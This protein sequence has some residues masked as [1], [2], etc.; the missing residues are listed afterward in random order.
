MSVFANSRSILHKGDGNTHVAAPPDVCKTPSPGGPIP[1][2]YVNTAS[3]SNLSKGA[4][5][6]KIEGNAA[7]K[8]DSE[9]SVSM[10][11]DAG[12]AGGVVSN[13]FK[14]KLTWSSASTDVKIEGKGAVRFTDPTG[15]NANTF[16]TAFISK[17][18]TGQAY[19]DDLPCPLCGKTHPRLESTGV[20][21]ATLHLF[22]AVDNLMDDKKTPNPFRAEEQHYCDVA[23]V[24]KEIREIQTFMGKIPSLLASA[25][26][27]ARIP[28]ATPADYAATTAELKRI[29]QSVSRAASEGRMKKRAKLTDQFPEDSQV[30][31]RQLLRAAIRVMDANRDK[32]PNTAA[33]EAATKASEDIA[34]KYG[35]GKIREALPF[36]DVKNAA[37]KKTAGTAKGLIAALQSEFQAT[38]NIA[39]DTLQFVP[40]YADE[41]A[42][43]QVLRRTIDKLVLYLD[44]ALV[45]YDGL[46]ARGRMMG[47]VLCNSERNEHR[48][49][50]FAASGHVAANAIPEIEASLK[51]VLERKDPD[52]VGR[53]K[54]E[55]TSASL[56]ARTTAYHDAQ[57]K[58]A[59]AARNAADS[60]FGSATSKGLDATS[61]AAARKKA[62]QELTS[63][64]EQKEA[65]Q[66]RLSA[67]AE[68][69][70]AS[71]ETWSCAAP[72]MSGKLT[73]VGHN[74]LYISE[75]FYSPLIDHKVPVRDVKT[76]D[77]NTYAPAV[78]DKDNYTKFGH[79]E[80]VP[81]CDMCQKWLP[82]Y[83][84]EK[85][86][87]C[88]T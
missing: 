58:I 50:V 70:E 68:G 69:A 57:I 75:V 45:E 42:V 3:D 21:E 62:N 38:V 83:F 88:C 7:A 61:E 41:D 31:Q 4:K 77:G 1:V 85:G 10:G 11:D 43:L 71:G 59:S 35:S 27:Y 86:D 39:L 49:G 26:A 14:G 5:K 13:K 12:T 9:L 56:A 65:A 53:H 23:D 76:V 87:H 48:Y 52:L 20:K 37:D 22:V 66:Q 15:Q 40:R 55:A 74:V 16:N 51:A 30:S 29:Q 17:G 81:S 32:A 78:G 54:F 80:T 24:E 64:K 79:G 34:E 8:A 82:A 63:K 36:P 73:E 28:S 84:C 6:V 25:A 46:P 18:T 19:G 60:A 2:P 47:A 67:T 72:K 33:A 44:Q